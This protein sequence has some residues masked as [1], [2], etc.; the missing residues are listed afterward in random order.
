MTLR[1]FY[2]PLKNN[3]CFMSFTRIVSSSSFSASTYFSV[4]NSLA[5][6]ESATTSVL[7]ISKAYSMMTLSSLSNSCSL[8][9]YLKHSPVSYLN[10]SLNWN[11]YRMCYVK[12]YSIKL[13]TSDRN[14]S[15]SSN[16]AASTVELIALVFAIACTLESP[17]F[18]SF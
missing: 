13:P 15:L 18:S 12:F 1:T 8:V 2:D 6:S 4:N 7:R 16:L 11:F 10:S 14:S 3:P 9:R 5:V 17:L